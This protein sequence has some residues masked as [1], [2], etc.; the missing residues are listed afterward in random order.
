M[1]HLV[2]VRN[3]SFTYRQRL[4]P[5]LVN[6]NL[7]IAAG[8]FVLIT[9]STGCGKSTLLQLFNG[10]IP[11]E[12]SGCL[13]GAVFIDGQNTREHDIA[14]LS[15]SVGM[16]FQSPDDQIF[17][18]TVF[19]EVAFVLENMGLPAPVV[20]G[21]V[22]ES[23]AAVGLAGKA[24]AEVGQLSGGQKQRLALAAVLAA[25]PKVLVLDEPIS[26][27]DPQGA[28]GVLGILTRLNDRHGITVIIVEHRLHEVLP[29][30]SRVVIM[31]GGAIVWQGPC[32]G[33]L[34]HTGVLAAHHLRIPQPVA[35]CRELGVNP[36]SFAAGAAVKAIQALYPDIPRKKQTAEAAFPVPGQ[37]AVELENVT[38][39]YQP[40]AERVLHEIRLTIPC[41]QFVALMGNNGAGKSTLLQQMCGL[42]QP[43]T[44]WVKIL[45]K[46]VKQG[47]RQVG[48]VLQ[49]PD[50]MLFNQTVAAEIGFGN[51][52]RPIDTAMLAQ[53]D[54]GGLVRDFPLALSRGQRL[55]VAIAAVLA[56]QPAVVLLDEPT[57]GQDI[58]HIDDIV[59]LL[60]QYVRCGGTVVFCTHDTEVAAGIAD[61][62]I[63]LDCG[64]IAADD[65]PRKVFADEDLIVRLGL[66]IPAVA[67]ISARLYGGTALT[68]QEVVRYV[69]QANMA[70]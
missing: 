25:N 23:L 48:M 66:K 20:A 6:I 1:Q 41:G 15:R 4:T 67:A 11:H 42:L 58:G 63:V 52:G 59:R 27:L 54:L 10:L 8:E 18:A 38:F 13:Q 62:L 17:S 40:Q 30:C 45:G 31:D 5:S 9:G 57:T 28:A 61:R 64:R 50:L 65:H 29:L 39:A 35:V 56:R 60:Q 7:Q 36:G 32:A 3:V 19:E 34:E 55:R 26:Q 70:D 16:V 44:G 47:R 49:N 24:G 33:L 21:R 14:V 51:G 37:P 43:E 69:Q 68:V 22:Q 12:N 53:L 46:P 2:E